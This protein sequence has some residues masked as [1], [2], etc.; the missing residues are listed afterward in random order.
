MIG[1]AVSISSVFLFVCLFAT[2][3]TSTPAIFFNFQ[4]KR[5]GHESNRATNLRLKHRLKER[6]S[7]LLPL[8]PSKWKNIACWGNAIFLQTRKNNTPPPPSKTKNCPP[9]TKTVQSSFSIW[10]SL[11]VTSKVFQIVTYIRHERPYERNRNTVKDRF[12]YRI[13]LPGR[14]KN[15][16]P[17]GW[18][19]LQYRTL[20]SKLPRNR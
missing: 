20:K 6:Y 15:H 9:K 14:M 8:P 16:I 10:H 12:F 1:H 13:P 3:V 2:V 17:Q 5:Y 4:V 19:I 11:T 18:M 7:P